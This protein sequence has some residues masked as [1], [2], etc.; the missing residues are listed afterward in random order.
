MDG[1][2]M[3]AEEWLYLLEPVWLTMFFFG[4]L[5]W[6]Y[7]VAVQIAHPQWLL[8]SLTHYR[9]PPFNWQVD[10]VGILSSLSR[11]R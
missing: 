4:T 7:V 10:D 1:T 9:L 2:C 11:L 3:D 8:F 5:G 6:V